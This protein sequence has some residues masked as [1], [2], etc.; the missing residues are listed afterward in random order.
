MDNTEKLR[1]VSL[2]TGY[3]GIERG[4]ELAGRTIEPLCYVEREAYVIANLLKEIETGKL[5][6][7]PIHTD[8][9]TFPAWG[10]HGQVDLLTGGYP[11]QPFSTAGK[12]RGKDDPRHLWPYILEHIKDMQPRQVFF[13]NVYGHINK[14]LEQVI[15]DLE[16]AGY[17][18]TWGIF[19]ANE[20][21]YPHER[22]RVFILG[23]AQHDGSSGSTER[24]GDCQDSV[25]CEEGAE[26]S[27]QFARTSKREDVCDLQCDKW[28]RLNGQLAAR[29]FGEFKSSVPRT[30]YGSPASGRPD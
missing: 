26:T 30:T 27:V 11:C 9:K 22:K 3:A 13:E 23:N 7:A 5:A 19:S 8:V 14:G 24:R 6:P 4:L 25:R 29:E 16:R 15:D 28:R 17:D 20:V 10:F 1:T 12:Q 2:C 18:A 21:G